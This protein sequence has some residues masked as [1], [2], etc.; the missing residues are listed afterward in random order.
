MKMLIAGVIICI[1]C[2]VSF[3]LMQRELEPEG[4]E[5]N[6]VKELLLPAGRKRILYLC[7][8]ICLNLILLGF[9]FYFYKE[10]SLIY[11][12]KRVGLTVFVCG[13]L[14]VD[15]KNNRIPNR[16]ILAILAWRT[17]CL[18]GELLWEREALGQTVLQEIIGAGIFG[19]LIIVCMLVAKNSIGM[20]DLKLVLV[21]SACQGIYGTI[22]TLFVSMIAAFFAAVILLLTRK[23][24]RK[25]ALPFAPFLSIGLYLSLFLTGI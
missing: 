1:L 13:I 21:I 18:L 3:G 15:L 16:F 17:V 10:T 7:G 11:V 19:L 9:F 23:K 6:S 8:M 22:N 5:K 24:S 14:P 12:L 4:K 25:D 20:G 2:V